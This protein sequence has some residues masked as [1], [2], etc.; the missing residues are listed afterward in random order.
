LEKAKLGKWNNAR[1]IKE[2]I[3]E[4]VTKMKQ[5]RGKDMVIF[6][7]GKLVSSFT[8][9]GLIDEY[10]IIL[11]PVILGNGNLLFKGIEERISLALQK[12]KTLSSGVIILYYERKQKA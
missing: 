11:N 6:G 3:A 8:Q 5:E 12:S 1:L 7:S 9:L 4:E 2:N 10:R